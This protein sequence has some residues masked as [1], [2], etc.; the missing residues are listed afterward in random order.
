MEAELAE[1]YAQGMGRVSLSQERSRSNTDVGGDSSN[2]LLQDAMSTPVRRQRPESDKAKIPPPPVPSK[3]PTQQRGLAASKIA[4]P[5][6][7]SDDDSGDD[8]EVEEIEEVEET[9]TDDD[10]DDTRSR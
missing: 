7:A 6:P 9:D 2:G 3:M 1:E 10:G 4:P 5:V 8:E